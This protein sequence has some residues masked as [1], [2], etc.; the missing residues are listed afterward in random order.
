MNDERFDVSADM[1]LVELQRKALGVAAPT[2]TW[3]RSRHDL[4]H[5]GAEET[6]PPQLGT[7]LI[8][9]LDAQPRSGLIPGALVSIAIAIVNDGSEPG[10]DVR[11]TLPLPFD[12]AYRPGTLTID[13]QAA[14]DEVAGELFAEGLA[15]GAIGPAQRRTVTVKILVDSGLS[16]ITIGPHVLASGGAVV[17][18]GALS[19]RR[20][21]APSAP[22]AP[23]RP[24]YE[25][26]AEEAASEAVE[27]PEPPAPLV[28][29]LQPREMPPPPQPEPE[30]PLALAAPPAPP[31]PPQPEIAAAEAPGI[32]AAV[33]G[34]GGPVLTVTLDRKRIVAL[35]ALFGERSLG[36]IAH[37]LVLNALAATVP[38]PEDGEGGALAAF[39]SAQEQLLSRALIATRLGKTPSP[40]SIAAALPDFPPPARDRDDIAMLALRGDDELCLVRAFKQTEI[41]FLSRMLANADAP[42]FL[43]V[44]QL[45][46]G[47]CVNDAAIVDGAARRNLGTLLGSY[48]ALAAGEINRIFLRAKITRT[49]APFKDTEPAFDDAARAVLDALGEI[50]T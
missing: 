11:L 10:E 29:V 47:L 21:A 45:F 28:A 50:V 48:T 46:V 22:T 23:E 35:R 41:A 14:G 36:M 42:P 25:S 18:P 31:A 20:G 32:S 38:L 27:S 15:L 4:P 8:A 3:S 33:R 1:R 19:L 7:I 17:G 34:N 24:F 9:T 13:G 37:Y 40:E 12:T 43:R 39:V 16:D 44:A 2:S 6:A 30:P 5:A 26:D 49:A